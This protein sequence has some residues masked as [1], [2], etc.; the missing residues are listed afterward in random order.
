MSSLERFIMES[1]P[2][3]EKGNV[4]FA[5]E[6]ERSPVFALVSGM[7]GECG[8]LGLWD[9]AASTLEDELCNKPPRRTDWPLVEMILGSAHS[10]LTPQKI[11]AMQQ[12]ADST[13]GTGRPPGDDAG[14]TGLARFARAI[15]GVRHAS[16]A[17]RC[18]P[19]GG[20]VHT[21]ASSHLHV[22]CT[23]M[24]VHRTRRWAVES[25][26]NTHPTGIT[27]LSRVARCWRR[28]RPTRGRSK[29]G[30]ALQDSVPFTRHLTS[31][32]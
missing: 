17:V 19:N 18:Y 1:T 30:G 22:R 13:K 10:E 21:I 7:V 32:P 8:S 15:R 31:R 27:A 12:T 23:P 14:S 9:Y 3:D 11:D 25:K 5:G 16:R 26:K 2:E 4:D 29:A 6:A 20:M 28:W 24:G